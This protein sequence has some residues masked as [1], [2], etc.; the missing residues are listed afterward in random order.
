[1]MVLSVKV[2]DFIFA[3][4]P[5]LLLPVWSIYLITYHFIKPLANFDL[6]AFIVLAAISLIMVGCHFVNQIYDF[7]TDLINK[8][9]GFL[10]KGYISK[11]TMMTGYLAV[12]ALGLAISIF[13]DFRFFVFAILMVISGY[14][15]SAPPLRLKDRP[16]WGLLANGIGYGFIL[17]LTAPIN[18]DSNPLS[19]I[20]LMMYFF[21]TVSSVYLLTIII[22]RDGDRVA[23]KNTLAIRL[24]ERNL[25]ALGSLLSIASSVIS[26]LMHLIPLMALSLLSVL[27]FLIALAKPRMHVLL[28]ICKFPIFLLSLLAGYYY[29]MYMVFMLVLIICC[30]LYYKKRFGIIYPRIG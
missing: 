13:Q 4:R 20:S 6:R 7:Q 15:Y 28:F 27:L 1:M 17:P 21:M 22:D 2:D 9:N 8:K 11:S 23:G 12:T 19:L 16:I 3:A 14:L 5:M 26:G 30:R 24:S 29:P 25:I 18:S 10:Q